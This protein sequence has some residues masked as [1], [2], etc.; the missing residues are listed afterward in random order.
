MSRC[1]KELA[2]IFQSSVRRV[3]VNPGLDK[4]FGLDLTKLFLTRGQCETRHCCP[5]CPVTPFFDE[6]VVRTCCRLQT[7]LGRLQIFEKTQ[8]LLKINAF[9]GLPF[10]K[11]MLLVNNPY[12][13]ITLARSHT[14]QPK[15]HLKIFIIV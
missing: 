6:L 2:R 8:D 12:S 3:C 4:C 15:N 9:F 7:S 1:E 13:V 5:S 11:N 10:A 14:R